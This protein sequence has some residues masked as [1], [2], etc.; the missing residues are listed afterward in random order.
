VAPAAVAASAG[1]IEPAAR[2]DEPQP[3]FVEV[4]RGDAPPPEAIGATGRPA[5][6]IIVAPQMQSRDPPIVSSVI[7]RDQLAPRPPPP[8]IEAKFTSE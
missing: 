1:R 4:S 6:D 8:E 5:I 2:I 3:R 7:S